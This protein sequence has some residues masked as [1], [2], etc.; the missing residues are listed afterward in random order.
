MS[1]EHKDALAIGRR[2]SRVVRDYLEALDAHKPKRG[3]KRT[4]DTV[5]AR[6]E[7]VAGLLA[8][9][10]A[11]TRLLL[12]QEQRDLQAELETMSDGFDISSLEA[13]FIE[14][15]ASYSEVKGISYGVW[16]EMGVS[17]AVLRDAGIAR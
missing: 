9:A 10:E 8:T 2:Q 11:L 4:A 7:T 3:R 13:E 14:V 16:R 1:A 15:A 6:L 12:M 17:A 5:S